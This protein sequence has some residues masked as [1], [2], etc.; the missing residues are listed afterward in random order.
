[1]EEI[2]GLANLA[3]GKQTTIGAYERSWQ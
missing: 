3:E 2:S 1:L